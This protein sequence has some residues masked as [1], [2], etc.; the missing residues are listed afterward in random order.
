MERSRAGTLSKVD[1]TGIEDLLFQVR[2][3]IQPARILWLSAAFQAWVS[4]LLPW[5]AL[6]LIIC[7]ELSGINFCIRTSTTP[8]VSEFFAL[9][10]KAEFYG[11]GLVL[12]KLYPVHA[13]H[14][15][16]LA[17]QRHHSMP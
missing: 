6:T 11:C 5:M 3:M 8:R 1:S 14:S 17:S 2:A 13:L 7:P 16:C 4:S 9:C 15:F 12:L 10:A